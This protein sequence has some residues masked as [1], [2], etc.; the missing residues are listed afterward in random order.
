MKHSTANIQRP[1]PNWGR[2]L[3]I[4][5]IERSMLNVGCSMFLILVAGCVHFH[6]QPLSAEKNAAELESRSLTNAVLRVF[7]EKNLQHELTNWPAVEWDFD[8]L[9]LAAFYYHPDL[10]VARA[11]W[12]VAQAGIKTAGG[13]PN[14]TLTLTP[15]YDTTP[16][17]LS[18][19]FP[20]VNF[21]LPIETAG[22]RRHRMEAAGHLSESARFN[23]ATVAWQVRSGL[24]ASLL[25]FTVTAQREALIQN[26]MTAQEQIVKLLK[27]QF[28]AGAIS[29]SEAAVARIALQKLQLDFANA[30][31]Q[32]IEARVRVSE[33]MGLPTGVLDHVT[34]AIN[35]LSYTIPPELTSAEVRR[36]ALLSRADILSALAEY[37]AAEATLQTEIAKQYPD[38]HLNPG[39]QYDQGDNKWS[40][41]ISFELPILNQNR[42][43]I[44]EAKARREEASAKFNALQAKVMAEIDRAVEVFRISEQNAATLQ[45]L[46]DAQLKQREAV[47]GQFEAGAVN[48]LELM[49]AQFEFINSELARLDGLFKLQQ[50]YSAL[51]DAVQRPMNL[52]EEIFGSNGKDGVSSSQTKMGRQHASPP[53]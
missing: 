34:L 10:A 16:S 24:R 4:K 21:D 53:K 1:T 42:G 45:S 35:P 25:D 5:F 2:E 33:A 43:P 44:A 51:E 38:V 26:Q 39:Y 19:W 36:T 32:R 28:E 40:V 14:P 49:N 37:A 22:K 47:H 46:A 29:S 31:S 6:S 18:P 30:Q 50:A 15:G 48:Q 20:A 12:S 3:Y 8:T 17:P 13:R 41:G 27:Q 11:Q 52:P 9:T 23:I 7:L